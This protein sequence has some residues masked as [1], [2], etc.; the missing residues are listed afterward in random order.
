M[1]FIS[2][3]GF[4]AYENLPT[5]GVDIA[6]NCNFQTYQNPIVNFNSLHCC[7]FQSYLAPERHYTS[8]QLSELPKTVILRAT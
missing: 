3:A 7:S 6:V 8:F 1:K 5:V 4:E 2:T